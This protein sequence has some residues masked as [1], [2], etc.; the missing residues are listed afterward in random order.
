VVPAVPEVA[1][2]ADFQGVGVH[3]EVEAQAAAGKKITFP[4]NL[5]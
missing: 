5:S 3:L 2:L 1:V 4:C